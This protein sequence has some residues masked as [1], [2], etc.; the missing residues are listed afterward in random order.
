[1]FK[2]RGPD[3]R[4]NELVLLEE[5]QERRHIAERRQ[6]GVSESSHDEFERLM[7]ALGFRPSVAE[8]RANNA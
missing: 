2:V 3:R 7:S 5:S 1:M 6:I 8:A 4:V